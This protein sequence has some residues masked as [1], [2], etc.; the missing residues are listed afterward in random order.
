MERELRGSAEEPKGVKH[1]EREA[2]GV[3]AERAEALAV[4]PRVQGSGLLP[5][6]NEGC[7]G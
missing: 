1:V 7:S 6:R 5:G 4:G 2:G 3:A